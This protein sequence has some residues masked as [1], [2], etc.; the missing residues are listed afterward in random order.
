MGAFM[1]TGLEKDPLAETS[2]PDH[3]TT[4]PGRRNRIKLNSAQK[5]AFNALEDKIRSRV[6][7]RRILMKPTFNDMDKAHKGLVTRNQFHRVMGCLGIDLTPEEVA[8]LAGVYCDRGNHNDFNY[9]DFIKACDPPIEQ[10]EIAMSQLNAPY[11]DQAPS[12]YFT[13]NRI[14]PLDRAHS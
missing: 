7:K 12:K 1:Q 2:M 4:A 11:Q 3:T 14:S 10:E 9:V 13:G 5:N 8:V 6:V